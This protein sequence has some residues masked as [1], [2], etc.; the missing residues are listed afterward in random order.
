MNPRVKY[1]HNKLELDCRSRAAIA[2]TCFLFWIKYQSGSDLK[3]LNESMN[4]F[5]T[6]Y[7][8]FLIYVFDVI[9]DGVDGNI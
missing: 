7:V 2:M 8:K 5:S 1:E 4:F 6:I 9:F 3:L